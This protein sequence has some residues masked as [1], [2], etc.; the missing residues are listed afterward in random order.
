MQGAA[1]ETRTAGGV[2]EAPAPTFVDMAGLVERAQGR[3]AA[4]SGEPAVLCEGEFDRVEFS[5]RTGFVAS[6]RGAPEVILG[7]ETAVELGHPSVASH[8]AVLCTERAA[9]VRHGRVTCLGPDIDALVQ[10]ARQPFAQLVLLGLAP[11]GRPDPFDLENAQ[12]LTNRLPG[13]MVRSVPGRLWV[14]IG[15]AALARGMSLKTVG[16][17]LIAAYEADFEDVAAVEVLFVTASTR[18]VESLAPLATEAAVLAGR[19]KKLVLSPDGEIECT[20]L[21]CETCDERAVC[22]NIRDVARRR[23]RR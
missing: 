18:E 20:E 19:H 12:Y 13:H 9:L 1:D 22:D 10:G 15:K 4:Y 3:I 11:G 21:N 5:R 14:R 7:P 16:R 6:G 23:R 17:A 2:A 8:S